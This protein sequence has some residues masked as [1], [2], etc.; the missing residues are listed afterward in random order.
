MRAGSLARRLAS[1]GAWALGGK[2]ATVL[3][4]LAS[5]ML[6]SR[7][8]TPDALGGYLLAA[9]LAAAG[10][11]AG[12]AGL[13]QAVVRLVAGGL[14][15]GRQARARSALAV[16]FALGAAGAVGTGLLYAGFGGA[17]AA[18]LLGTRALLPL[19]GLVA[20]WIAVLAVQGL[21][22][23]A[24]RGLG[25]F[26]W[27][28][29]LGGPLPAVLFAA[30]LLAAG[31]RHLP[32]AAARHHL[33]SAPGWRDLPPGGTALSTVVLLAVATAA[34]ATLPGAWALRRRAGRLPRPRSGG[35]RVAPGA[36]LR[37]A[38]PLLVTSLTLFAAAHAD[39]WIVGALRPHREVAV[40]G[41]AARAATV[42]AMPL[43]VV[44]AVLPPVV[45]ELHAQGRRDE[46]E[47]VLRG[48]AALAGL[49][50]LA[51][52]AALA[53]A[54]GPL[55]GLMYG[56]AYRAGGAVLTLLACGQAAVVCT[57]SCGLTLA[58]T[59]RQALL[60]TA[61]GI[62]GGLTV[63]AAALAARPFGTTG[64]AAATA[65]GLV[66]QNLAMLVAVR[67]TAGVWTHLS[68]APLLGA[69]RAFRAGGRVPAADG[70]RVPA[71]DGRAAAHER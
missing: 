52:L 54:G 67:L 31:W 34:L 56:H 27:A 3:G 44:N 28:A 37:I 47:R 9:S 65:A 40:Y 22:T 53:I 64:V 62:G 2:A 30:A 7:L 6:L 11:I 59:G 41:V 57:G 39:L 51:A 58:M 16:T 69:A 61:T 18:G 68:L 32:L 46:L 5:G 15:A 48:A 36:L 49:P 21:V 50:A 23:E 71:A 45:A 19:T 24:F 4:G 12:S 26:R 70:G 14:G 55:L 20:A 29:V 38:C 13:P 66:L 17:L 8:L 33:P 63:V 60:A 25:D 42:V 1:G 35:E 10:A 43:L